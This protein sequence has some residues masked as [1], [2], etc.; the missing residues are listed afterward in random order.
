MTRIAW[1]DNA[2]TLGI[3]LVVFAH[4]KIN[5]DVTTLLNK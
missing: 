2:K 3:F 1:V 4:H 5:A